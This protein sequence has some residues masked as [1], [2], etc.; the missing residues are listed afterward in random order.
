MTRLFYFLLWASLWA[1]PALA[2]NS[3]GHRLVALTA[4]QQLSPEAQEYFRAILK[5]HPYPSVRDL[6]EASIWPDQVR[7]DP[8][9]HHGTWHYVNFPIFLDGE[10]RKVA[11]SGEVDSA[12]NQCTVR[13]KDERSSSQERAVALSWVV[14]L[15]GDLHQPL[16][17]ANAYSPALPKGDRGG[18]RFLV[19][20]GQREKSLHTFWDCGGGLIADNVSEEQLLKIIAEW[21]SGLSPEDPRVAVLSPADWIQESFRLARDVTYRDIAVNSPLSDSY[22]S[23]TQEVSRERLILAGYR[24]GAYLQRV[25]EAHRLIVERGS[26]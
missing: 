6:S 20:D 22:I 12:L 2:W 24:L 14:H 11:S 25:Y 21:R 10:P 8:K 16:H 13:L 1:G 15:I 17:A 23:K 9:Y 3:E 26:K 18:T 5:S 19:K 4:Q 7:S